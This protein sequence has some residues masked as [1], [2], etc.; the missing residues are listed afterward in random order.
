MIY[1]PIHHLKPGMIIETSISSGKIN[2]P[3]IVS[4]QML[5]LD[6]IKKL[7]KRNISGIYI[8]SNFISR[9]CNDNFISTKLK[10]EIT[11]DLKITFDDVLKQNSF[12]EQNEKKIKSLADSLVSNILSKKDYSLNVIEIK[13]YDC[14]TYTHSLNVGLLS[15]LLGI[16]M[17]L[18]PDALSELAMSGFLHDIG[19]LSISIDIIKKPSS[20]TSEEFIEIKNHPTY[21]VTKLKYSSQ[22]STAISL[23]IRS[24]HEKFNGTGYPH[25]QVGSKIPLFGRIL[26]V[27]DVYDAVT[28]SRAYRNAW[29]PN[30]AIE[31][32]MARSGSQF[33]PEVLKAFLNVI[34]IYPDG[35]IIKLSN[36][37][38]GIVIKN[39][40]SQSLRPTVKIILPEN[41]CG[42]EIDLSSDMDYLSVTAVGI[43]SDDEIL[44]SS[45]FE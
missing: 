32:M 1:V 41:Y 37:M 33:D 38:I 27:A 24:H 5:T 39:T 14:Y 11:A 15:V 6:N 31:Y 16:N 12:S 35:S 19:K 28:T 22:I 42:I 10:K 43:I 13:T 3:L 4:G 45:L 2:L 44:P 23:G 17:N 40:P 20:L 29:F 9:N 21:G 8:K 36:G 30:E 25:N 26:A 18:S 34:V 7:R